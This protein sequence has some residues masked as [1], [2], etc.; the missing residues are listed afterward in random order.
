VNTSDDVVVSARSH[1]G[2]GVTTALADGSVRFVAD[3]VDSQIWRD[4][5]SRASGETTSGGL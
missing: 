4:M 3:S 1:H 5:G 2:D